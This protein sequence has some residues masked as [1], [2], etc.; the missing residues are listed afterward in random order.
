M[1]ELLDIEIMVVITTIQPFLALWVTAITFFLALAVTAMVSVE[2][3]WFELAVIFGLSFLVLFVIV[4]LVTQWVAGV[5]I[6]Q[7]EAV[8]RMYVNGV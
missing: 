5:E 2:R 8:E 1:D 6:V 4:L 7:F 3:K